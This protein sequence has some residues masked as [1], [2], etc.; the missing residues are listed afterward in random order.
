MALRYNKIERLFLDAISANNIEMLETI[1]TDENAMFD[2]LGDFFYH[3][4]H[5]VR[6]AALEVYER[7]ALISYDIEGLLH[8]QMNNIS[9]V[10]FKFH[11]PEA[12]PNRQLVLPFPDLFPFKIARIFARFFSLNHKVQF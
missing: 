2:V 5:Q 4:N 12:H 7:R 11:L 6:V 8:E 10:M 9:A 1:I 3:V